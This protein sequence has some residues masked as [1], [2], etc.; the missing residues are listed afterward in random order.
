MMAYIGLIIIALG[1]FYQLNSISK[2]KREISLVFVI[3]YVVGVGLLIVDGLTNQLT[4]LAALNS[5]TL[6]AAAGVWWK[7]K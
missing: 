2:K 1:W 7:L 3:G 5:V 4:T 6:L